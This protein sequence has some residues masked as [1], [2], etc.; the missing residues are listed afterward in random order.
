[1]ELVKVLG[2]DPSLRNSGLSIV[3]YNTE[4]ETNNP[5]A[6]KVSNA[7]VLMNPIK[8]KGSDA[9][10]NMIDM[11]CEESQKECY[12]EVD[13]VIIES[14]GI[15]F[16]KAWSSVIMSVIAH[17]AGAC[18]PIFNHEKAFIYKPHEWNKAKKKEATHKQALTFLGDTDKW[19]YEKR[20]KN[21]KMM[22][23]VLDASSMAL[24]W[25]RSNYIEE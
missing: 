11:L 8:Y 9:I 12:K 21:E 25:I 3:T 18:I 20:I 4:L 16:N 23:H 22:E 19:H 14:P 17:I 10:L 7:Q 13:H 15:M 24:W 5:E 6:F 2:I 1:M